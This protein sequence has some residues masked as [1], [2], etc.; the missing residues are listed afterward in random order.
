MPTQSHFRAPVPQ[1][2]AARDCTIRY[3]FARVSVVHYKDDDP[4]DNYPYRLRFGNGDTYSE[5]LRIFPLL[6]AAGLRPNHLRKELISINEFAKIIYSD[7][8]LR[9][10]EKPSVVM[11]RGYSDY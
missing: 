7:A 11:S 3:G 5:L 6:L 4:E 8:T 9:G 10:P 2:I 1:H